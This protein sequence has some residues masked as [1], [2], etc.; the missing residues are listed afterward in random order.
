MMSLFFKS[1]LLIKDFKNYI[2]QNRI[3]TLVNYCCNIKP[4][5]CNNVYIE[6]NVNNIIGIINKLN[7]YKNNPNSAYESTTRVPNLENDKINDFIEKVI[8]T[9]F[10]V[11]KSLNN[12]VYI[13]NSLNRLENKLAKETENLN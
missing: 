7:E 3:K 10:N 2:K 12:I 9:I 1:V 13:G 5:K 6:T 4:I 8:I 11:E